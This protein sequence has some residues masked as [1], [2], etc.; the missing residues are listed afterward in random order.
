MRKRVDMD[1]L[2]DLVRLHRMGTGDREVARLLSMSPNTERQYRRA[3]SAAGLLEGAVDELPELE[4]LKRA[5]EAQ[6]PQ[7]VAPQQVST[8]QQWMDAIVGLQGKGL[9]PRGIS[10]ACCWR[11]RPSARSD[12]ASLP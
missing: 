1:R 10:T 5:V 7:K 9:G 12:R 6:L 2:Q 11:T 8:L 4:V 3:L